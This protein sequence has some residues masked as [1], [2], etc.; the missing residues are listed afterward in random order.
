MMS[1]TYYKSSAKKLTLQ[2]QNNMRGYVE[3]E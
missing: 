2:Y 3:E 1:S